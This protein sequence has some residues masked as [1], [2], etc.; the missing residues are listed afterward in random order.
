MAKIAALLSN[1]A[2]SSKVFIR[3]KAS[4]LV[5]FALGQ[6]VFFMA[7]RIE[8][9]INLYIIACLLVVKVLY[10]KTIG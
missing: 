2:D 10:L 6:I 8:G 5:D 3:L 9:K 1:G 7:V 4:L